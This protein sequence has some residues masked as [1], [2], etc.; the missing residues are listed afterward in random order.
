MISNG[1]VSSNFINRK[2]RAYERFGI[3]S[4]LLLE[5]AANKA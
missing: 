4:P 1:S 5:E 3:E 2:N